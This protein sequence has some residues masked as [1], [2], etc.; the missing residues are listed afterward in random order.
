MGLAVNLLNVIV[1]FQT[2]ISEILAPNIKQTG[3][4]ETQV[5]YQIKPDSNPA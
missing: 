1:K 3:Q 5:E 4:L 2:S